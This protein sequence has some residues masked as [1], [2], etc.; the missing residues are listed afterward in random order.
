MAEVEVEEET[1]DEDLVSGGE[2]T[3][4]VFL[5]IALVIILMCFCCCFALFDTKYEMDRV[6]REEEEEEERGK[7]MGQSQNEMGM[8]TSMMG[9]STMDQ[10][11]ENI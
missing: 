3:A 10:I 11:P 1:N 4:W 9:H 5:G 2:I 7:L 8:D 6:K